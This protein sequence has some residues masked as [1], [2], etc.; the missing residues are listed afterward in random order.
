[1]KTWE[2]P[3]QK[4]SKDDAVKISTNSPWTQDYQSSEGSAAIDRQAIAKEQADLRINPNYKGGSANSNG[5]SKAGDVGVPVVQIRLHSALPVRQAFVRLQEI[6]AG[7][8]KMDEKKRAEFDDK[9]K[10]TL[11]CPLCQK[12]YI[13][14]LS[15]SVNTSG[16]NVE[17]GLFQT[18]KLE[19]LKGNVWL[20]NDK[21]ERQELAQFIPP[22]GSKDFAVFFF[23]RLDA[24]GHEFLTSQNKTFKFVFDNNFLSV[25]KNP[26]ASI[27]PKNFGFDLSKLMIDEKIEF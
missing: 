21:G 23:P 25:S 22:K 4:W 6:A 2:K 19:D 8:D 13:V 16:Q 27:L 10:N 12:F 3:F 20:E 26:Y 17:D 1:Q 24:K 18:M 15:K 7:Y 9:I 11:E 5:G 14:T